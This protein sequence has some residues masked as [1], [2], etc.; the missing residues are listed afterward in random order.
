VGGSAGGTVAPVLSATFIVAWTAAATWVAI[1]FES[2]G[3]V[4]D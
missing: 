3:G 2:E 1:A 4:E